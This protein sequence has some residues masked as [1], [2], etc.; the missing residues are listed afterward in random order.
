M[1]LAHVCL[2]DLS[3][4]SAVFGWYRLFMLSSDPLHDGAR[5]RHRTVHTEV[6]DDESVYGLASS[7]ILSV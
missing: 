1:A 5:S 3:L 2:D 4:S 7:V 6:Q